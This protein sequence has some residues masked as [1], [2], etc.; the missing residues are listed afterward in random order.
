LPKESMRSVYAAGDPVEAYAVVQ[1][2]VEFWQDQ[3][4]VEFAW[5]TK[6]GYDSILS[7]FAGIG[8]NKK[9]LIWIEPSDSPFRAQYWD[10]DANVTGLSPQIMYRVV[11]VKKAIEG[12]KPSDS[13]QFTIEIADEVMPENKGPWQVTFSPEGVQVAPSKTAG[14]KMD[15]RRFTQAFL[16]EPS[17]GTLHLNELFEVRDVEHVKEAEKLLTPSPTLCFEMF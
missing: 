17:L 9:N 12:L 4:I 7:V 16:G 2:K 3:E 11:N 5:T 15:I 8:I 14:F 13:G 6:A 10:H 1:H